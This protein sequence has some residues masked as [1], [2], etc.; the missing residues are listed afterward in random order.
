MQGEQLGNDCSPR[1]DSWEYHPES[2]YGRTILTSEGHQDVGGAGQGWASPL[3]KMDVFP[4]SFSCVSFPESKSLGYK[5][6]MMN[7]GRVIP[8]LSRDHVTSVRPS[9]A[10]I[11]MK[12][13]PWEVKTSSAFTLQ[14]PLGPFTQS[15]F[16]NSSAVLKSMVTWYPRPKSNN[17]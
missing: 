15:L 13:G 10:Q 6:K 11:W 17:N 9:M 7:A 5:S 14:Y 16:D 12:K 1:W 3:S 8:C 2:R 4:F